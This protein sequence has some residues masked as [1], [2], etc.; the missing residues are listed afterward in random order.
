MDLFNNNNNINYNNKNYPL[1]SYQIF[2]N[3]SNNININPNN[4][5][6]MSINSLKESTINNN[7][8]KYNKSFKAKSTSNKYKNIIAFRPF[9]SSPD[10]N[11]DKINFY[12][13]SNVPPHLDVLNLILKNSPERIDMRLVAQKMNL[14]NKE[15]R[16]KSLNSTN[17]KFYDYNII[18]GYKTNN[19]IKSYTPKLILKKP[20]KNKGVNKNGQEIHQVFSEEEISSLFYKKCMDLNIPLKEELMN[21]FTDFIKL[22]CINRI[23]DLT[24]CKLGFNSMIVL[25]EILKNINS[26]YSRLILGKNNFGDKGI[27]LLLESIGDNSSIVELNLSSNGITAKGGK[28]IFGYLL[29]QQ[30]IIS[31]DL[32]SHEGI[33]RN[34]ICADGVRLI[35]NV[36]QTNFFIENLDLSSNSI[37]T[38]GFKYLI[39]GLKGNIVLKYLNV[40][41][42]E[43]DEKGMYYL[44]DNLD[45]C[46]VEILDVSSNPIGNEGCIALGKC[47]GSEKFN[48]IINVNL[49]DCSVRFNGIREF[50]KYLKTNKKINTLILNKNNLFSKKWVYLEDYFLNLNL[51]HLGLSSCSLNVSVIDISKILQHHPTLRILDLSHNQINDA[52]FI[53]FKSFPKENLS[54]VELDFSRNYISDKSGKY[55]FENLMN[56]RCLQRLNF[57]DNQLQNESAN[58][59]IESLRINH[60]LTYV[61]FK[62]NRVPIRIM[63]EINIRIQN[64]KLIEKEK[65]LPQ[66]KREIKDLSFDPEEINTLKGRILLQNQEKELSIQKLKEDN[67]IIKIKKIE[68]EKELNKVESESNDILLKIENINKKIKTIN[69]MK[70]SEIINYNNESVNIEEEIANI[71]NDIEKITIE[72]NRHQDKYDDIYKRLK[73]AYDNTFKKYDDQRK[74]LMIEI[75]QLKSKKKKYASKLRILDKLKNPDKYDTNTNEINV[76]NRSENK[77]FTKENEKNEDIINSKDIKNNNLKNRGKNRRSSTTISRKNMKQESKFKDLKK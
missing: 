36:L 11:I 70:E 1:K 68:N 57:F 66:L 73:R 67:K 16:Q 15:I 20:S 55:F 56:N 6:N 8:L 41:N 64:N 27:E 75:D 29:N 21:R 58:A 53:Y 14:L 60:S 51:R 5:T 22:K 77:N 35:E 7:T 2:N 31:L 45:E 37:K 54:L 65:F 48:E 38:E 10:I 63:K 33:N 69:E 49:S 18:F 12:K 24:D 74:F 25:S 59:I 30:S 34:R 44:K 52:S 26:Q 39:N 71:S 62:S 9:S 32:S 28:L 47:L 4:N 23:I 42:N 46:K 50:F 3:Q 43:I 72:N 76:F 13:K 19:I 61:N 17:K 40:S